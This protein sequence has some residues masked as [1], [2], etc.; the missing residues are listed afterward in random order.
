VTDTVH[1]GLCRGP[2]SAVTKPR[3]RRGTERGHFEPGPIEGLG[4]VADGLLA[5]IANPTRVGRARLTGP[6]RRR[7]HRPR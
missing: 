6:V 7:D 1:L 5:E 4:V 2:I 3:T